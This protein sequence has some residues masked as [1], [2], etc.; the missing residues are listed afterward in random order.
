MPAN[1]YSE[2]LIIHP[3]ADLLETYPQ[4]KHAANDL[5]RKYADH[6]LVTDE[7][8]KAIG[9]GL[10]MVLECDADLAR[11]RQAAGPQ[12]VSIV[13]ESDQPAIQRL[14]WE[15]LYHLE[16]GFLGL[17]PGFTLSRR[18]GSPAVDLP[19]PEKGPLRVLLFT[20]LP[21]DL[22]PETGRLNVE[23]EQAQ[24]LEALLP[25]ITQGLIELEMPDDGRLI[26][27][28]QRV[29]AF[30]PHLLFLS[31]H[32]RFHHQPHSDEPSYAT[33]VFED[34]SGRSNPVREQ[35]IAPVFIG[36]QVGCVVLSACE[37]GKAT[38]D[39]LNNGLARRLSRLGLPHVIGMRES[40]LDRAGILFARQL[41]DAL[42]Q[43]ERVDVALQRARQAITRPL[44]E[45][46]ARRENDLSGVAELSLGQW[47]LPQLISPAAGQPLIDWEFSP[48]PPPV[49][50]TNQSLNSISLPPR[51]VG[52]R[53]EL[54][55][56]KS[57]LRRG[58]LRQLL[59]TGPGGQG[60]TALTGKLAQDLEKWDGYTVLAWSVG[61]SGAELDCLP[62]GAGV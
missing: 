24:V 12:I 16:H 45:S 20:S 23:E 51:F 56:L 41:S 18:M 52:R 17:A 49:R 40:L 26:T 7:A 39:A 15:T 29:A 59:I 44:K 4:L 5:A 38:S 47:S 1:V 22:N 13:I 3:P 14:P 62:T 42:A 50:Q 36:S 61:P 60:K 55:D 57:R 53:S 37:T 43:R 54:R 2:L 32:G 6:E 11:I 46:V 28:R 34:D 19:A 25:W 27:L 21:D 33:F 9:Q 30:Q 10:W 31:G 48:Q 35:D 8:L 58:E